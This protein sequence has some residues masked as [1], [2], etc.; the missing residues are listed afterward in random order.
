[1]LDCIQNKQQLNFTSKLDKAQYDDKDLI[2]IKTP[3]N[4]PYYTSSPSYERTY[5]S[6]NVNGVE[7]EYVKRRVF[8]DTLEL[9]CL[10][11][12][13]KTKLQTVKNSFLKFSIDVQAPNKKST[14]VVKI[15]LPDF[16]QEMRI[17]SL[18]EVYLVSA[19]HRS[20]DCKFIFQKHTT[21]VEQP[22]KA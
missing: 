6:V 4:L 22:P 14:D 20:T 5:G 9:L 7:Y 11:N 15:S 19:K 17:F 13:E 21:L 10:P 2:S 18:Q 12:T 16:I 3:L 1:M 8:M